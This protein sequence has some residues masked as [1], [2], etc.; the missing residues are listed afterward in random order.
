MTTSLMNTTLGT[1]GLL[2]LPAVTNL[3]NASFTV[4]G[5]AVLTLPSVQSHTKTVCD[6]TT[7]QV[8]GTNSRLVL[9][10]GGLYRSLTVNQSPEPVVRGRS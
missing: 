7:W 2:P 9:P 10:W 1:G 6:Y 5:G 4:S 3:D 8:S